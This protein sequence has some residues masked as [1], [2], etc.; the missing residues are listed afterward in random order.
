MT[1]QY[2]TG[3]SHE[4]SVDFVTGV[5]NAI[6]VMCQEMLK[7][8]WEDKLGDDDNELMIPLLKKDKG[9]ST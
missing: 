1:M 5:V 2:K 3:V 8:G 7:L 4:V 9:P 6:E